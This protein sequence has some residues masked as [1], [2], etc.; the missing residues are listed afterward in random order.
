MPTEQMTPSAAAN[1]GTDFISPSAEPVRRSMGPA[2][3]TRPAT[4]GTHIPGNPAPSRARWG[5]E[6]KLKKGKSASVMTTPP[7]AGS[8][9]PRCHPAARKTSHQPTSSNASAVF[10]A[11]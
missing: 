1:N 6:T 11:M 4:V 10:G 2:S 8:I 3:K 5:A 9:P 7:K